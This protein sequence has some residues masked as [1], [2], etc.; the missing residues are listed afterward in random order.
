MIRID[1]DSYKM[2]GQ[3][4]G[5]PSKKCGMYD[6]KGSQSFRFA[7]RQSFSLMS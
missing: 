4:Y 3:K 1:T 6:V 7:H 2:L 5:L